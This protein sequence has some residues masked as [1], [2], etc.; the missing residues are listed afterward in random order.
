MI[1]GVSK[2]NDVK[3]S[4]GV[5][6]LGSRLPAGGQFRRLSLFGA[7]DGRS[8]SAGRQRDRRGRAPAT[9]IIRSLETSK[10]RMAK[11]DETGAAPVNQLTVGTVEVTENAA[12]N[13]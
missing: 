9:I 4:Y 11:T 3:V 8:P 10:A 5:F 13:T 1:Q 6:S 2:K 7:D 12:L